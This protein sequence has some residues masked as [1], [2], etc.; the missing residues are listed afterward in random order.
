MGHSDQLSGHREF[1]FYTYFFSF[2][3]IGTF[4]MCLL[5]Y[6]GSSARLGQV[7]EGADGVS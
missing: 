6:S 7:L 3:M 5:K 4:L 1:T 2:D